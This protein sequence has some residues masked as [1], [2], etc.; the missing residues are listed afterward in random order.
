[1]CE[2]EKRSADLSC[3]LPVTQLITSRQCDH[4][5]CAHALCMNKINLSP[6]KQSSQAFIL[7]LLL[8]FSPSILLLARAGP[9]DQANAAVCQFQLWPPLNCAISP[10]GKIEEVISFLS[11]NPSLCR[12]LLL[13]YLSFSVSSLFA[14][15]SYVQHCCNSFSTVRSLKKKR[16]SVI[17]NTLT[18]Q[19][20][21]RKYSTLQSIVKTI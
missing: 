15:F 14:L 13:S 2:I 8:H 12:L 1:M 21:K 16:E 10:R 17:Y 4:T 18:I 3:F 6:C 7:L 20:K 5:Q 19:Y 9:Y 11:I